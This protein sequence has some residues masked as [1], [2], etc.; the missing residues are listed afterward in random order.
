MKRTKFDSTKHFQNSKLGTYH[1]R[2]SLPKLPV[3]T[4]KNTGKRITKSVDALAGHPSFQDEHIQ[5]FKQKWA[6]F[7]NGQGKDLDKM[8]K[9]EGKLSEST[10]KLQTEISKVDFKLPGFLRFHCYAQK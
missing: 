8:L 5:E 1:F 4:L 10:S 7:E 9:D 6:D 3:P 2:D